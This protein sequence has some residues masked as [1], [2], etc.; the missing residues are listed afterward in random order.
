MMKMSKRRITITVD[1]GV[2]VHDA[3]YKLARWY[4]SHAADPVKAPMKGI[5]CYRDGVT[6]CRR[7]YRIGEC[8]IAFQEERHLV[9]QE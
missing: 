8:F 1:D 5:V 2:A 3:L 6:L 4:E 7:D 9:Q